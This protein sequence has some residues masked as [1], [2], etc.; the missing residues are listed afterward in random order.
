MEELEA[1]L[2][3]LRCRP[4][5]ESSTSQTSGFTDTTEALRLELER[6]DLQLDKLKHEMEYKLK[7]Q[8]SLML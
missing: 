6:K 3:A 8:D 5:I 2:D 4:L 7:E 1:E